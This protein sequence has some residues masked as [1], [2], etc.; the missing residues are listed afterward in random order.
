MEVLIV[1]AGPAGLAAA[2]A[3]RRTG[4]SV[5][6]LDASDD[7]GGQYWRHL[8][9]TRP[10][11]AEQ[12]LH[13]GWERYQALRATLAADP[14]VSI[15]LDTHVWAIEQTQ[16]GVRVD[17]VVGPADGSRRRTDSLSPDALV[18]ATGAHDRAL[19][20]PGWTLPGVYTAGAAQALAKGERVAVGERVVVSGAGPFLLPVSQALGQ[21][22]ARVLGVYEAAGP[23]RLA[24]SWLA[25]PGELVGTRAKATELAGYVW[26]HLRHR[27]PYL[28]GRGVVAIHGTEGVEAVTV[29]RLDD[30]WQPVPGTEHRIA[31]DAVCLGHGFTPR[32]ELPVA[33]GCRL[34]SERFVAIDDRQQTSV[35]GIWAAGELTGVGGA[36][37]AGAEGWLAGWY[38]AGGSVDAPAARQASQARTRL[39]RFAARIEAAHGIEPGW[40]EWLRED[41]VVC[42]CEEVRCAALVETATATSSVGLRSLKLTTRAGLGACQGRICGRNVE[43]LLA[44]ELGLERAEFLDGAITD[45]RPIAAPIRLGELAKFAR[46]S[47]K[48]STRASR[49]ASASATTRS[50]HE[51]REPH[52]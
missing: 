52:S 18:L 45:K 10:V 20:V 38:A 40:I 31:C 21:A 29:A 48:A 37:L 44:R 4:A 11:R 50:Y 51:R 43:D 23:A 5:R 8:P 6:L 9:S 24:R 25:R 15:E 46:T 12:V 3:A 13:H 19:P 27:V 1:G 7:T 30:R 36:D 33:A 41:T 47:P 49:G 2:A 26:H 14:W 42:R 39:T 22:G 16:Q 34:T 17:I 28:I 32:L 35:P